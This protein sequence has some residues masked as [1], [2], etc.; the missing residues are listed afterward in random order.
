MT[1]LFIEACKNGNLDQAKK[2]T[3][4]TETYGGPI[5]IHAHSDFAFQMACYNGHLEIAR[6]LVSLGK[7]PAM[8]LKKDDP[9]RKFYLDRFAVTALLSLYFRRYLSDFRERMYSP[10]GRGYVL[11]KKR[12]EKI[13]LDTT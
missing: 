6:W 7:M 13:G 1:T 3:Q 12:F 10:G 9:I 8:S 11:A 4:D 2:M 5:D